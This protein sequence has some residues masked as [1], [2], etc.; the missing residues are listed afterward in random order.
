[1]IRSPL[2]AIEKE[3]GGILVEMIAGVA[4]TLET[5]AVKFNGHN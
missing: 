5:H 4:D 3:K 1:M 2:F